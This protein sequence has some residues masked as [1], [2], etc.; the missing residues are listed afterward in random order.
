MMNHEIETSKEHATMPDHAPQILAWRPETRVYKD[1]QWYAN[2]LRFAERWEAEQSARDLHYRWTQS[3][4]WRAAPVTDPSDMGSD[5]GINYAMVPVALKLGNDRDQIAVGTAAGDARAHNEAL[6]ARSRELR[7][8]AIV[9]AI[10]A[11]LACVQSWEWDVKRACLASPPRV[12]DRIAMRVPRALL[13][14][15]IASHARGSLSDYVAIHAAHER[16]EILDCAGDGSYTEVVT[17]VDPN[18]TRAGYE[19]GSAG[20]PNGFTK[21]TIEANPVRVIPPGGAIAM[22]VT[23]G[24][25]SGDWTIHARAVDLLA[26]WVDW[27]LSQSTCTI[28]QALTLHER[29]RAALLVARDAALEGRNDHARGIALRMLHE[30]KVTLRPEITED[31][32][33][34]LTA[35]ATLKSAY[36]KRAL[37]DAF[38]GGRWQATGFPA[39]SALVD[40]GMLKRNARGATAI[41]ERGR[42]A[43]DRSRTVDADDLDGETGLACIPSTTLGDPRVSREP[44]QPRDSGI[45]R[46]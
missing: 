43:L 10:G 22:R 21:S 5:G 42:A 20:G 31:E 36:R 44:Q 8:L 41:T 33:T 25:A 1:P 38:M 39:E 6:V 28:E 4:A 7:A 18:A 13:P 40:R 12:R 9:Q 23:G 16:V 14:P 11:A 37:A 45:S 29:A 46:E 2:G 35:Y 34:I 19:R 15:L 30:I 27:I 26:W 32:R 24:R 17:H 3:E